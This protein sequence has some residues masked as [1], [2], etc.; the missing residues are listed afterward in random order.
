[1]TERRLSLL[2]NSIPKVNS[3]VGTL[4]K[5]HAEEDTDL[6]FEKELGKGKRKKFPQRLSTSSSEESLSFT[7][8]TGIRI[9]E[10]NANLIRSVPNACRVTPEAGKSVDES[11]Q[12]SV[13]LESCGNNG[14]VMSVL[15]NLTKT[16]TKVQENQKLILANQETILNQQS[17]SVQE[18]AVVENII[19]VYLPVQTMDDMFL[20]DNA[21]LDADAT[22]FM[23]NSASNCGGPT[24]KA[25]VKRILRKILTDS[26][27]QHYSWLGAKG[28]AKFCELQIA[29]VV[30]V[31]T[32][33][34]PVLGIA[35]DSEIEA[36]IKDWLRHAS[37][38]HSK[39][40]KLI[41]NGSP[42]LLEN[43]Q[44]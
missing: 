11:T 12:C 42:S 14:E 10:F 43:G 13:P 15:L 41:N 38:R 40:I 37:Y 33:N 30:F 1:M 5:E 23:I 3:S 29:K 7:E 4:E 21:L 20:L 18:K 19:P 44:L 9:P 6:S 8:T 28:K 34:N 25:T 36:S 26:V 31:A 16:M 39:K 24:I 2:N 17:A 32:R 27:A 22:N 35:T